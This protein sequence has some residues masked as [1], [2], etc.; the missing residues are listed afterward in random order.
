MLNCLNNRCT[1]AVVTYPRRIISNQQACSVD[2]V[3]E[4]KFLGD[5][6]GFDIFDLLSQ[7][8]MTFRYDNVGNDSWQFHYVG[9]GKSVMENSSINRKHHLVAVMKKKWCCVN[10]STGVVTLTLSEC[11]SQKKG[12][13]TVLFSLNWSWIWSN[14][15]T[16]KYLLIWP[17]YTCDTLMDL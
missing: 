2:L 5:W 14:L 16:G 7:I 17:V 9:K 10:V 6:D 11:K 12:T 8:K 3:L 4:M 1:F 15:Y 13:E